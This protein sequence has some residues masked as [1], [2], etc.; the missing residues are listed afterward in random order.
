DE[1]GFMNEKMRG[2][3]RHRLTEWRDGLLRESGQTLAN[4]QQESVQEADIGDRASKEADRAL[5][6]RTRDRGRK[7]I[8]KIDEAL[9]RLDDGSYGYCVESG[10][11]INLR[12]L[13][14]RPIATLSI[15][16]QER[17]ERLEKTHKDS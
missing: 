5:E 14:A 9:G 11:P 17:H 13:M 8:T 2:Y 6:L 12:R 15:E 1:E 7:L 4:L 3:F 10:D 16:A